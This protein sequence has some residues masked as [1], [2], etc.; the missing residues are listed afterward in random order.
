MDS[1]K[2]IDLGFAGKISFNRR[3]KGYLVSGQNIFKLNKIVNKVSENIYSLIQTFTQS[4][5]L[6]LYLS[7]IKTSNI[8]QKRELRNLYFKSCA[9]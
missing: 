7:A 3:V 4:L 1:N 2:S 6:S 5:I 8:S 9:G